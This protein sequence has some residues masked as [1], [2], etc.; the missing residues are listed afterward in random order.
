[1]LL[2]SLAI[3]G[4]MGPSIG[5]SIQGLQVLKIL[6]E[7]HPDVQVGLFRDYGLA[8]GLNSDWFYSHSPV[9]SFLP[10]P[11]EAK[12]LLQY[13]RLLDFRDLQSYEGFYRL[14]TVDFFMRAVGMSPDEV[15][16]DRKR[17]TWLADLPVSDKALFPVK[18]QDYVLINLSGSSP[19]RRMPHEF[20]SRIV[21]HLKVHHPELWVVFNGVTDT[22]LLA[23]DDDIN[24]INATAT[25]A[26]PEKWLTAVKRARLLITADS[27]PYH[28]A[29]GL[30]TQSL[31]FF[32]S[33]NPENRI[34]YYKHVIGVDLDPERAYSDRMERESPEKLKNIQGLWSRFNDE[35]LAQSVN[36]ALSPLG[37]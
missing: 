8:S 5:D 21:K 16:D 33:V 31:V 37:F 35:A 11:Q 30:G 12:D 3:L 36:E 1:M 24:N 13:A 2:K 28:L 32:T 25:L 17:P 14:P 20:A 10:I 22:E 29:E 26:D 19:A 7:K 18:Q 15:D 23:I 34:G 9:G 27:S 4:G 6:K